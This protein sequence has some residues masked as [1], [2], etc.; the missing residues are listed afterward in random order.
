MQLDRKIHINYPFFAT[1]FVFLLF[2][3]FLNISLV[4]HPF[5]ALKAFFFINSLA[6]DA[7]EI[8][9]LIFL[10]HFLEK[11]LFRKGFLCYLALLF[12]LWIIHLVDFLLVRMMDLSFPEALNFILDETLTSFLELL[13]AANISL[14]F[15]LLI[16]LGSLFLP[17]LGILVYQGTDWLAKKKP[18]LVSQS[19]FFLVI[20]LLPLSLFF[21]NFSHSW[22]IHPS[23]F[24]PLQKAMPWKTPLFHFSSPTFS[25]KGSLKNR[26]KND[27]PS[28]ATSCPSLQ[29]KANIYLFII[30]S[31]RED[32]ITEQNTP[33]IF[34]FKKQELSFDL[35]LSSSNATHNSW[36]SILH[37]KYPFFWAEFKKNPA[38]RGSSFLRILKNVGYKTHLYA[39][40]E[41]DYYGMKELLFGTDL[42][43]LHAANF[44]P[45]HP[46]SFIYQCDQRAIDG[47]CRD[48][49]QKERAEKSCFITFLDSTHFPYSWPHEKTHFFPIESEMSCFSACPSA[50]RLEI[51]KNRYRNA[52]HGVDELFGTFIETLKEKNLYEEAIIVITADH[53]E[54]FFEQG[55][56]FHASHLSNE[57]THIPLYMKLGK[58]EKKEIP[59]SNQTIISHVDILP[60]LYH[61]LF[62][63]LPPKNL[64]DG[65]SIFDPNKHHFALSS[66]FNASRAPYE[67]FLHDGEKKLLLRFKD[68]KAIFETPK[69]EFLLLKDRKDEIQLSTPE[70]VKREVNERFQE[71]FQKIFS[72]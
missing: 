53:G 71:A 32:F 34:Q 70:E 16:G 45:H 55:H 3:S 40:A 69:I 67:F 31:L 39:A 50:Y 2:S 36:F 49:A 27:L 44:F 1:F 59:P 57:Q 47:L 26:L 64:Y 11:H 29:E 4:V 5:S 17:F 42:S 61:Y 68:Q 51:I 62:K 30:E 52:L 56:L 20:F 48:L 38:E 14:S 19:S 13:K 35:A 7:I 18:L 22:A 21:W 58:V 63:D 54:E 37:G 66:R 65:Q 28:L 60:T 25:F 23:L 8:A 24:Q 41:L 33:H 9:L 43:L 6:E 10:T 15:W 46:T 12:F 72:P